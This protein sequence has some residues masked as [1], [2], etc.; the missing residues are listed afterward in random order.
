MTSGAP[1][2]RRAAVA[3]MFYSDNPAVLANDVRQMLD[4]VR[5]NSVAGRIVAVF[6]PHAGYVYSGITAAHAYAQLAGSHP[7]LVVVVS[8]SHREFFDGVSVYSGDA[9]ATPLGPVPVDP[10]SRDALIA[11]CR[12]VGAGM[13]GHRTEHALEVQLPFLQ[14][15]LADFRLLP[16]VIGNPSRENC[17][18]LGEAL[19]HV[20]AGR[21]ALLVASTD[22]SHFHPAQVAERMD[23]VVAAD[24]ERFDPGALM[25]DMEQGIA[26]ACGGGPA[27]A[28]MIAARILSADA[29]R[30]LHQTHSGEVTGERDSVVGYLSAVAYE[31]STVAA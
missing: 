4:G 25:D 9:Y 16:L 3:G 11:E 28:V 26:E 18:M 21:N 30:V 24:L 7:G 23:S 29:I 15:A 20:L 22:L 13:Q 31:Q 5:T 8:P 19:G 17:M 12:I 10:E 14:T 27:A 6:V 2:I 1:T